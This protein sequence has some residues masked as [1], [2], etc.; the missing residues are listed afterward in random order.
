M[1]AYRTISQTFLV[2]AVVFVG[3]AN[4]IHCGINNNA[5]SHA[6]VAGILASTY[7][8]K[9]A[10]SLFETAAY[11]GHGQLLIFDKKSGFQRNNAVEQVVYL[12]GNSGMRYGVETETGKN[13]LSYI[14]LSA[15]TTGAEIVNPVVKETVIAATPVLAI[16][17]A[18]CLVAHAFS[19]LISS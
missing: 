5:M 7:G 2:A 18:K 19:S 12:L 8:C 4:A 1:N 11:A 14:Q 6:T 3:S 10:P 17:L 16:H 13:A 9:Y 15:S